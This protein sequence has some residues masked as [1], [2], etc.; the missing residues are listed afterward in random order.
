MAYYGA[1]RKF[2]PEKPKHVEKVELKGSYGTTGGPGNE[3][4][5][6]LLDLKMMEALAIAN[7]KQEKAEEI[8]IWFLQF[9]K[10]LQQIFSDTELH[11]VF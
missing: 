10:L 4:I 2:K 5:K 3:F 6:Y 7:G 9:E 1:E 11:L 8:K